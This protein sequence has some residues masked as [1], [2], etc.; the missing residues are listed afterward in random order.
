MIV[1]TAGHVDHG[2]TAL[3]KALTGQHTDRTEEERR[4]GISIELGY[5]YLSGTPE[6]SIDFVDVPGHEKFMRTLLAGIGCVDAM[7]LVVAADDGVMPQTHEHIELIGLLNIPQVMV[8]ISKSAL[9]TPEQMQIIEQDVLGLVQKQGARDPVCFRVDSLLGTGVEAIQGQLQLWASSTPKPDPIGQARLIVDRHFKQPGLGSVVTGTLLGGQIQVGDSLQLSDN[10][11]LVRVR[12][13]QIHH[14]EAERALAGQRCAINL[15]G[16]LEDAAFGR[17]SQLLAKGTRAPTNRFDARLCLKEQSLRGNVQL[18]IGSAVVNARLVPLKGLE[19]SVSYGQWVLERPLCCFHGDHFIVRDPASRTLLGSGVIVDPFAPQRGRQK[20][21][22][23]AVIKA[24]DNVDSHQA[25]EAMLD[26]Q[27]EGVDIQRFTLSRGLEAV[28]STYRD[29]LQIGDWMWR[30]SALDNLSEQALAMVTQ[31]HQTCPELLGPTR[32]QLAEQLALAA[33]SRV[34]AVILRQELDKRRLRQTGPC[35]HLL[36]HEPKPAAQL[37][38]WFDRVHRTFLDCSPRPPV[39]GDLVTQLAV[40][41]HELVAWLDR[42]SI[43]GLLV[44]VARNRYLLPADADRLFDD[45]RRLAADHHDGHISTADFR[46]RSGI[47]RNHSVAV[48]EYFD[49]VGLTRPLGS[50]RV[51]R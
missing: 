49:R 15:S 12:G 4:R 43:A 7:M 16:D 39:I 14:Q 11:A 21:E 20:P 3:I 1:A 48:L 37:L 26:V 13:I 46:D 36:T 38:E 40:D 51:V 5:A 50:Y 41:K 33:D 2:K 28:S 24:M 35:L 9:A 34:L 44:Y 18:H 8:V 17:G 29:R 10:G 30:R 25:L 42:L 47:G 19:S 23:L 32:P 22:R 45:A 27:P 31:Y 6:Q